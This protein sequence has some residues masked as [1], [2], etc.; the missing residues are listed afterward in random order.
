ML[1]EMYTVCFIIMPVC[2]QSCLSYVYV[3][4][5]AK[6]LE[7]MK[8]YHPTICKMEGALL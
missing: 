6:I 8:N 5:I 4:I 7:S 2:T 1:S 3:K